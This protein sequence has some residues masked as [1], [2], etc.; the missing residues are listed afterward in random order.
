MEESRHIKFKYVFPEDYNP[1]YCNGAYGGVST[2]G[3]IV[4]NFFLERMPMPHSVTTPVNENGSLGGVESTDPSDLGETVIRYISTGVVLSES[5]AKSIYDWLGT[6][7]QELERR[8]SANR[9]V[10]ETSQEN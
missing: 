5:T 4:V 8:K 3:E 1:V 6:Q 7:I 9:T 10:V 2:H